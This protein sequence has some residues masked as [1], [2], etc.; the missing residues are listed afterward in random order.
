MWI[1]TSKGFVSIVNDYERPGNLLCRARAK[2][3]LEELFP[4]ETI[5][6]TPK[7][8]Y[9]FRVSVPRE[10]AVRII[11]NQVENIT[12]N[13]FKNSIPEHDYHEACSDVWGVMYKYQREQIV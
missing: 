8:D 11:A 12:Y 9:R 13:N 7:R 6:T 5:T 4:G 2:K 1:F 3:H 10:V